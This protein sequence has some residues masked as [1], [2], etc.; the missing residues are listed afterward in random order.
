MFAETAD[1]FTLE[2]YRN[3]SYAP[4]LLNSTIAQ[5]LWCKSIAIAIKA[6]GKCAPRSKLQFEKHEVEM[7]CECTLI[8]NLRAA[9]AAPPRDRLKECHVAQ[10]TT[11]QLFR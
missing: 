8:L 9:A 11:Y 3:H 7:K 1:L 4:Q 5:E 2:S 10:I 6:I